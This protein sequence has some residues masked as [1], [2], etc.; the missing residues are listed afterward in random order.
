MIS[1]SSV[2]LPPDSTTF[3]TLDT[4][5][6]TEATDYLADYVTGEYTTTYEY[7]AKDTNMRQTNLT[8]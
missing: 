6:Q 3:P 1:P 8:L 5:D 4:A 7:V 2:S